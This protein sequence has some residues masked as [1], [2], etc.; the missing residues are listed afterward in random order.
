MIPG[1][2]KGGIEGKRKQKHPRDQETSSM[3]RVENWWGRSENTLTRPKGV[4]ED[5]DGLFGFD[6][7]DNGLETRGGKDTGYFLQGTS[8][9]VSDSKKTPN[10]FFVLENLDVSC[11]VGTIF[12]WTWGNARIRVQHNREYNEYEDGEMGE[13]EENKLTHDNSKFSE[14]LAYGI[15]GNEGKTRRHQQGA[16][17]FALYHRLLCQP[18]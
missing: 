1:I 15:V 16:L 9:L 8:R 6:L 14:D 12:K 2:S 3:T 17:D 7:V 11:I 18:K 10:E 13:E 4:T 5:S